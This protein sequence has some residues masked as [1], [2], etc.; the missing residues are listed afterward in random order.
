MAIQQLNS[1]A[2]VSKTGKCHLP[3]LLGDLK[4]S[5]KT[6]PVTTPGKKGKAL[7]ILGHRLCKLFS[8]MQAQSEAIWKYPG[9][10][11][12]R[13]LKKTMLGTT[14]PPQLGIYPSNM[15]FLSRLLEAGRRAAM[16]RNYTN[17]PDLACSGELVCLQ[18]T[19]TQTISSC[20]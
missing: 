14:V 5:K 9:T 18:N 11:N 7:F 10:S 4:T 3:G 6:K 8:W 12:G 1:F 19:C 13:I 16:A 17:L 20:F 15:I 2:K